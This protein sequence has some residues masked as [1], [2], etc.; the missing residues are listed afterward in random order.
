MERSKWVAILTGIV[1]V[2]LG[3]GYLALVQLLDFRGNLQPA[4]LE[5]LSIQAWSSSP[6]SINVILREEVQPKP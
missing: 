4:P 6:L 1:A 2:L 3:L 5:T